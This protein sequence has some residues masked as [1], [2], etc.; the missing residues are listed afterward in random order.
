MTRIIAISVMLLGFSF[1]KQR[2]DRSDIYSETPPKYLGR[3]GVPIPRA[4]SPKLVNNF[5]NNGCVTGDKGNKVCR[6][7]NAFPKSQPGTLAICSFNISFLGHWY[8]I[9]VKY[10]DDNGSLENG[11]HGPRRTE[12]LAAMVRNCDMLIVQETAVP[13]HPMK[14][15]EWQSPQAPRDPALREAGTYWHDP[16]APIIEREYEG[17]LEVESIYQSHAIPRI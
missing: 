4:G 6:Y 11:K 10:P 3:N 13:A 17:D 16:N 12:E 8:S 2:V 5:G 1:C 9:E 15:P 7:H 14:L